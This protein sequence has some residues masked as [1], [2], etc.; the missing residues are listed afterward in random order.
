LKKSSAEKK[1]L[2]ERVISARG[3][4]TERYAYSS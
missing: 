1:I 2:K 4:M 3:G